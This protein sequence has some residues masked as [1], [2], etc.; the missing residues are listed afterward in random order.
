MKWKS[1]KG[2]TLIETLVVLAIIG[3]LMAAALPHY[4]KAIRLAKQTAADESKRQ[5]VIGRYSDNANVARETAP[6][7]MGR[8]EAQ[9]AFYQIVDA[10][11]FDTAITEMVYV[12][13]GDGDFEAY[14]NTLL[15]PDYTAPL[16]FDNAG[17]L[18]A[19]DF[20][21]NMR[22]LAP[23]Y[24]TRGD[25]A[26]AGGQYPLYWDFISRDMSNMTVGSLGA[27]VTWSSGSTEYIKY[28]GKFPATPLVANLSQDFVRS[29]P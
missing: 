20:S 11:K 28:P 2:H 17:R 8:D 21:N 6:L 23:M 26:G 13:V 29:R 18:L 27:S 16:E 19:R 4:V 1:A 12:V 5:R 9:A 24:N 14:W 7:Q 10:G 25:R 15:N 22:P 3:M